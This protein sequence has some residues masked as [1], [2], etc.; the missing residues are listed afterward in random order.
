MHIPATGE[1]HNLVIADP[2]D[3]MAPAE[4]ERRRAALAALK[5][6]PRDDEANRAVLA[7]AERCWQDHLGE[8]R[9]YVGHLIASFLAAIDTQDLRVVERARAETTA[10][11]D[12]LEGPAWL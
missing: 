12:A 5:V 4:L 10:A 2:D 6:H 7:R 11:L 3:Q 9:E 1:R 8:N